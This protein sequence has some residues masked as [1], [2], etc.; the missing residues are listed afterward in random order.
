MGAV[1]VR[2]IVELTSDAANTILFPYT[3]LDWFTTSG[4]ASEN[5]LASIVGNSD[6]D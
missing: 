1:L 4:I 3:S 6:G 2:L 5:F